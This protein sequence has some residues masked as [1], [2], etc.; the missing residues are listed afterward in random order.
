MSTNKSPSF[1]GAKIDQKLNSHSGSH[2]NN[3]G[4]MASGEIPSNRIATMSCTYWEEFRKPIVRI[5]M[6]IIAQ[7]DGKLLHTTFSYTGPDRSTEQ[8]LSN[9]VSE[10]PGFDFRK[11]H[12]GI[13][14]SVAI[15]FGNQ[16]AAEKDA[17]SGN[18]KMF[19]INSQTAEWI[20]DSIKQEWDQ[21]G[22]IVDKT[23]PNSTEECLPLRSVIKSWRDNKKR[24]TKGMN[25]KSK[26]PYILELAEKLSQEDMIKEGFEQAGIFDQ[27]KCCQNLAMVVKRREAK[28]GHKLI[29]SWDTILAIKKSLLIQES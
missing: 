4:K 13:I 16:W 21:E 6:I 7:G 1:A 26:V 3:V 12:P 28:T 25:L 9:L 20:S 5:Y 27:S 14:K 18:K 17:S 8:M 11:H 15:D 23:P 10:I 22:M 19:I 29:A 24:Q 2:L